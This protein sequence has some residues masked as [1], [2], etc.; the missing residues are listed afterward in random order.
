M[1][2][3]SALLVGFLLGAVF[4]WVSRD[5]LARDRDSARLEAKGWLVSQSML[6]VLAFS[7]FVYAPMIGYFAAFHGD[8]FY[9]YVYPYARIPSAVNL[10]LVLLSALAVPVGTHM[11]TP[12]ARAKKLGVVMRSGQSRRPW[13]S[14]RS[15]G[16]RVA[17]R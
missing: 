1:P 10:G 6:V 14:A 13:R 7:G 3:P 2:I 8:W 12:A 5:E 16:E 15:R 4:A 17:S 11:A 9:L